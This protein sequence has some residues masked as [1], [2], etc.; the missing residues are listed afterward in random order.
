MYKNE[1]AYKEYLIEN[2]MGQHSACGYIANIK[3]LIDPAI[4]KHIN[5][6]ACSLLDEDMKEVVDSY[7]ESI[8]NNPVLIDLNQ[9]SHR[10]MSAPVSRY[11]QFLEDRGTTKYVPQ[12]VRSREYGGFI[13]DI[14]V[15][16][17]EISVFKKYNHQVPEQLLNE[18]NHLLLD[19]RLI[20]IEE[21]ISKELNGGDF[22]IEFLVRYDKKNGVRL[23]PQ[24]GSRPHT[25]EL[26]IKKERSSKSDKTNFIVT[27]P[28]GFVIKEKSAKDCFVKSIIRIGIDRIVP[29]GLQFYT[30]PL[31][32]TKKSDHKV[33]ASGQVEVRPGLFLM[34]SGPTDRKIKILKEIDS[35][36]NIGLEIETE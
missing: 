33:Y 27:F 13:R 35:S 24:T 4:K 9:K 26:D 20:R 14:S 25:Q 2:G 3:K 28:D 19:N 34:T 12:N 29:L 10:H 31:L 8:K 7:V 15:V 36:L 17:N 1:K 16:E 32:G 11:A 23:F 30:M 5:P 18:Y 6:S 21:L 22:E